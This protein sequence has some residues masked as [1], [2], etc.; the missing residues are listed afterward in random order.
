MLVYT[1]TLYNNQYK[2]SCDIVLKLSFHDYTVYTIHG[3]IIFWNNFDWIF[4]IFSKF[5]KL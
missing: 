2:V 1:V 5:L 3:D 4:E